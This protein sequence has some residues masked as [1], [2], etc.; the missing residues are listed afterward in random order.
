[1]IMRVVTETTSNPPGPGGRNGEPEVLRAFWTLDI[2]AWVTPVTF[3]H[4]WSPFRADQTKSRYKVKSGRR[5]FQNRNRQSD[6]PDQFRP[7]RS[8]KDE[9]PDEEKSEP[10]HF[11]MRSS[12]IGSAC[13]SPNRLCY[14][15]DRTQIWEPF[16]HHFLHLEIRK[17]LICNGP[18]G[19]I[20]P[21]VKIGKRTP[22]TDH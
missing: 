9:S 8:K 17:C 22:T 15:L 21:L 2:G 11:F 5:V 10:S 12:P 6:H 16:L 3:S 7:N 20:A 1:M 4:N 18:V 14:P 19:G 13:Q